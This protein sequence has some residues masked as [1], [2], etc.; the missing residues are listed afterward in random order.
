VPLIDAVRCIL[1]SAPYGHPDSVETVAFYPSPAY[2]TT[3]MVE[4]RL[5]DGTIGLGEGYLGVFA[6]TLFREIV[7][8][9]APLLIGQEASDVA[10]RA[11]DL[12]RACDYWGLEGQ[13]R[14]AT[15]AFEIALIDAAA[16]GAGVPAYVYLGGRHA[17]PLTMYASGGD[18]L[19]PEAM[20]EELD[21]AV[22]MT[23]G[24]FKM[25]SLRGADMERCTWTVNAAR[26]HHLEVA[27]DLSQ[28]LGNT[29]NRW[30]DSLEFCRRLGERTGGRLSFLE[31][32][33]GPYDLDGFRR[34]RGAA[35]TRVAGG[36]TLTSA[37]EAVR[38]VA[39]GVYDIVQPDATLM[40]VRAVAEV[41]AA[42]RSHGV[43]S[44]V[45]AWGGP[46]GLMA[47]YHVGLAAGAD[48]GE[49]PMLSYCLRDEMLEQPISFAAGRWVPSEAPGLGVRLTDEI[50]K[51]YPF[52]DDALYRTP[53]RPFDW[54]PERW[55]AAN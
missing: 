33:V 46:V 18:A 15:A 7:A 19:T 28:N 24:L 23:I 38:R 21:R 29:P 11:R 36:E 53:G 9:Q 42:A 30:S 20:A 44:A 52:R 2:R 27:V 26:Q 8:F 41:C 12:R 16:R 31:E 13:V 47:N 32:A 49:Y 4:V 34:L 40:G 51:K 1:L 55:A 3:S 22:A 45:H 54:H 5:S 17:D 50:E 43:A 6:P 35:V 39:G 10:A 14:H 37:E 48:L 25:R